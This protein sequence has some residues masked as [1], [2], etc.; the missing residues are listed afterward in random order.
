MF[1]RFVVYKIIRSRGPIHV[2]FLLLLIFL[3]SGTAAAAFDT[4]E[5]KRFR[6]VRIT[7][8]VADGQAGIPLESDLI[9]K[10]RKDMADLRLVSSD[11]SL[12]PFT[13]V[14]GAAGDDGEAFPARVFRMARKQGKW[15]DIWID[16]QA[17]VLTQGVQVQTPTREF[18]R[19]VEIRGSDNAKESYVVKMDGLIADLAGPAPIR[20]LNVIYHL[21]NF[22]YIHI[23]II[24]DDKPPLKI[25][26][27]LCYPPP[28][29]SN[30]SRPLEVRIRE[31]RS[32]N[33]TG[34]T[35]IVADLGER[36]FPAANVSLS[37]GSN[38]F[39]KRAILY[40]AATPSSESWTRMFEGT[41]FR[42]RRDEAVK[43]DLEARF[44]PQTFR[45]LKLELSGGS[46]GAVIVDKLQA[47]AALPMAAFQY[48]RGQDYRLYYDNPNAGSPAT[49]PGSFSMNVN[50][51]ASVASE[52]SLSGE[53]RNVV[54]DAPKKN[55][56]SGKSE[57][58]RF[59]KIAGVMMLLVGLVLL[60]IFMLRA[61]SSRRSRGR[62]GNGMVKPR[63][64]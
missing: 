27:V 45:Y 59:Q 15:T 43:E 11:G 22:Q 12:V 33:A 4:S 17:K 50:Q 25:E 2:V 44:K 60:F 18:L 29:D 55:E 13:I 40:G 19:K 41:L 28:A 26:G 20:S 49:S 9:E 56:P 10:C 7:P 62:R 52:I 1:G 21:N 51:L 31:N 47:K 39:A 16:K 57:L 54:S 37:S 63:T 42:L 3:L 35:T 64:G 14:E 8:S 32:D 58:S 30:L 34:T 53:Q 23:R 48:R 46:R 38:E 5:W 36:R 6:E 24:D 61:R